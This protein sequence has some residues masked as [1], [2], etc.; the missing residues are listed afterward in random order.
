MEDRIT[1]KRDVCIIGSGAGGLSFAAAAVQMG[2]S[3]VLVEKSVMGGDDLN[4][5]CVPS[6]S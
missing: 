2:A 1:I 4:S 6:K 5:G 3:V